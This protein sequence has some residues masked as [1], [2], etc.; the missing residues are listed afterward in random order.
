[1]LRGKIYA[2]TRFCDKS[3]QFLILGLW[4]AIQ[5]LHQWE[6]GLCQAEQNIV[7]LT[8]DKTSVLI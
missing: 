4:Q 6:V 1:M 7:A 2:L 3:L 5:L 8:E